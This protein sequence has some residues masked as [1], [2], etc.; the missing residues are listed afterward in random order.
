[1]KKAEGLRWNKLEGEDPYASKA[2][3]ATSGRI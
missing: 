1:M 2:A 3:P